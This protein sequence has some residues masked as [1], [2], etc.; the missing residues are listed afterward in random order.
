[1][2]ATDAAGAPITLDG[3]AARLARA[4]RPGSGPWVAQL[5]HRLL[6][7]VFLD[8]WISL[9]LQVRVLIGARG[10]LPVA[11]VFAA[12][13]ERPGS[14]GF[15]DFPTLLWLGHSD[16][17]LTAGTIAGVVLALAALAGF[18]PRL[19]LALSTLL[20]FSYAT[21]GRLF[22]SFQWDNLILE[23]GFLATFLPAD[24]P[25][26]A[27]HFLFRVVLF[28][29]YFESGIAKWQSPISDW[30]DGSAMTYYYETAPL[31]TALAWTA[32]NWP[33]WWHHFESWAVLALELV[34]PFAIFGPR[35]ARRGA[36]A[37][38]TGFQIIN[39]ATANYGF[40][41]YLAL[42]LHVF[43]L[44]DPT[45]TPPAAP[46]SARWRRGAALAGVAAFLFASLV[47]ALFN[48][49]EPGAALEHLSW[50]LEVTQRTR[51][52]NAYHLFGAI[53]RERIE[54]EFQT[55]AAGADPADDTAW[56]AHDL[57]HK[58]GDPTRRPDLVAP[59]QPRVDFQLWFYGLAYQRRP[60]AYV[61]MLLERMCEDAAVVQPLFRAPLPPDPAAVRIVFWEYHFTT[62]ADARA[63]DGGAKTW[64]RRQRMAA[65]APITCPHATP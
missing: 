16:A 2:T 13:H 52:I 32:H 64:W 36:A 19:C 20:Y 63:V 31:P 35:P 50:A 46:A 5:F 60:P 45:P 29:L 33:V 4:L 30:Q 54:P 61:S 7:L 57:L 17:L 40:F 34:V 15:L 25:A 22:L 39:I 44:D 11:D 24:R 8:A 12:A 58:P 21:A 38:L 10:L 62:G 28:K 1:V 59:H 47:E 53:T 48:F 42:A 55:L 26:P 65:T 56:R 49:T 6:A 23:C 27:V 14:I 9:G 43:L 41:C 51:V 37:A 18:Y 3:W